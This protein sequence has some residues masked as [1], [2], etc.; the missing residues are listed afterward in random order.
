MTPVTTGGTIAVAA[1]FTAEPVGSVL[2]F[3]ARRLGLASAVSFAPTGQVVQQLLDPAGIVAQ[4]DAPVLLLRWQDWLRGPDG[5]QRW[6]QLN[7]LEAAFRDLVEAMAVR[8]R[9]RRTPLL[10]AICPPAPEFRVPPYS[11]MLHRFD[12]DLDRAGRLLPSVTVLRVADYV[13]SYSVSNVDDPVGDRLGQIPYTMDLFVVLGTVLAR[14]LMA[15]R[16][17]VD[18][19]VLA[20]AEFLWCPSPRYEVAAVLRA[21][22]RQGRR[23]LLGS[24]GPAEV[25]ERALAAHPEL[26]LSGRHVTCRTARSAADLMS[27][28]ADPDRAVFLSAS[29]ADCADVAACFPATSS[30]WLPPDPFA[31]RRCL[32]HAWRLD[33]PDPV[34]I[35][36]AGYPGPDVPA[37]SGPA[38]PAEIRRAVI[39]AGARVVA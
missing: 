27:S 38:D 37:A 18:T 12:T 26:V 2:R 10:L 17:P 23:V 13:D 29:E 25:V 3:W 11:S 34:G 14:R 9:Q 5:G 31:A 36:G 33:P 6:R 28:V 24:T 1:T 8:Q 30:L 35:D 20:R 4:A 22:A 15:R 7:L 16:N 39:G 19:V 32:A 21:Q